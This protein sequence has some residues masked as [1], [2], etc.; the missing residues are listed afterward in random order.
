MTF[1]EFAQRCGLILR[2]V[3]YGKWVRVP[4]EDHPRKKNGAY[5]HL[6]DVAFVQ[7]HATMAEPDVWT[8]ESDSEIRIDREKMQRMLQRAEAEREADRI[9]A[10][11]KAKWIMDNA[12]L[13]KH[14]YLDSHGMPDAVGLVWRPDE[15]QNL[16]VIPMY[17]EGK[18]VGCQL[19]D[20]DGQKKFLRGQRTGG[21]EFVIG[22]GKVKLHCEGYMTGMSIYICCKAARIPAE[23]HIWFSAGN[24]RKNAK[25]GGVIADHDI[26]GMGESAAKATGLRYYLP[27]I[28]GED[29]NDEW[30]RI[31]TFRASQVLN[32]AIRLDLLKAAK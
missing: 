22:K 5:K 25:E 13:E 9:K 7:N 17:A 29:F 15:N 16:L 18:I 21:A 3:E 12:K 30:R 24:L 19:I 28:K 20:R 27:E 11:K 32:K 4:T 8:P 26:S 23:V 2:G 6:G 14:A 10:A 31:G 1:E